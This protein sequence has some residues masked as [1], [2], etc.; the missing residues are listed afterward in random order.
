MDGSGQRKYANGD[1]YVG[2]YS[3]GRRCGPMGKLKFANDDLYVGAW[4]DDKFHDST[5]GNTPGGGG[6]G[7]YYFADG[8]VLV[9]SFVHGI[10]EGKFKRQHPNGELD[11]IRY[12]NDQI[13]GRGVRWNADRTKTWLIRSIVKKKRVHKKPSSKKV[14]NNHKIDDA[15]GG[16]LTPGGTTAVAGSNLYCLSPFKKK[17]KTALAEEQPKRRYVRRGSAPNASTSVVEGGSLDHHDD[18]LNLWDGIHH[19][20]SEFGQAPTAVQPSRRRHPTSPDAEP[21]SSVHRND[22]RQ[23]SYHQHQQQQHER[24]RHGVHTTDEGYTLVAITKKGNRIPIAVAV[25]IGYECEVGRTTSDSI[26]RQIPSPLSPR[27]SGTATRNRPSSAASSSPQNN[28]RFSRRCIG[29]NHSHPQ[30]DVVGNGRN[31]TKKAPTEM[32]AVN[33][34]VT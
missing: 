1:V 23:K 26:Q 2:S 22:H 13:V 25:S 34:T 14:M 7:K 29:R 10:K 12:E 3:K 30:H 20:H 28:D 4:Y 11:I 27:S 33:G 31:K 6:G 16:M 5:D 24:Q 8:T 21:P 9:G 15:D 32:K 17:K 18:I 19:H